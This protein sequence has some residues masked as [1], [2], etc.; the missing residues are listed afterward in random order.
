MRGPTGTVL[1]V[2]LVAIALTSAGCSDDPPKAGGLPTESPSPTSA[3]SSPSPDTP[4]EQVEAAVRAY[5]AELTR[6]ARTNDTSKLRRMSTQ[7]CPCFGYVR[8]IDETSQKNQR[9]PDAAWRVK[10]VRVHELQP[11]SALAQVKYTVDSYAVVSRTG[12]VIRRF[13]EQRGNVDLS[14]VLSQGD[15]IISNSFDLVS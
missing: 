13:P 14:L 3:T 6:A 15:W 10:S 1:L 8:A 9:T 7:G 5:Y 11:N 2:A 4:E 12:E